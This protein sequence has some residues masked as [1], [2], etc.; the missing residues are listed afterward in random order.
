MIYLENVKVANMI[1]IEFTDFI[2]YYQD[3][4][5]QIYADI[6]QSSL[7]LGGKNPYYRQFIGYTSL[8]FFIVNVYSII[9]FLT[10]VLTYDLIYLLV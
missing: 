5:T 2:D 6:L 4:T 10:K 8:L 9:T 7:E 1:K 3:N